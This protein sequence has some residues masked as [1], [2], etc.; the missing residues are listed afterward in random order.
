MKMFRV[1]VDPM[2]TSKVPQPTSRPQTE[3]T[4]Q[5][6]S[7]TTKSQVPLGEYVDFEEVKS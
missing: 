4:P 2:F 7:S 6:K 3:P 1:F 5:P